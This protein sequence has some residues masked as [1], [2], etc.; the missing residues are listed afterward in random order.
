MLAYS[1]IA[2]AGYLLMAVS[3][4][5]ADGAASALF[6]LAGYLP[7]NLVAFAT[8]AAVRNA[9]GGET[10]DHVRG[11]MRRNPAI[12]IAL[13]ISL[14]SLLGLPPLVGFAGKFQVFESV[15]RAG[16]GCGRLGHPSLEAGFYVLLATG[17]VNTVVSAGYYLRVL[18][19]VA[20]DDA[21][22]ESP[23]Q[24]RCGWFL[25]LLAVVIVTLGVAWNPLLILA[26]QAVAAFRP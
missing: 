11:L 12:G 16:Q 17:V 10:L 24:I 3:T 22:D 26:S 19:A 15:Y 5:T 18:K 1:T 4:L 8:V 23:R 20:L 14:L 13:T 9:T 2:H 25:G 21:A 6:Y 7:T